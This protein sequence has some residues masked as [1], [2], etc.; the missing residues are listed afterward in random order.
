MGPVALRDHYTLLVLPFQHDVRKADSQRLDS[1]WRPWWW[2]LDPGRLDRTG[3]T[4]LQ[5]AL[6]EPLYFLPHVRHVLYPET[7]RLPGQ[8]AADVARAGLW[9]EAAASDRVA[10][11]ARGSRIEPVVRLTW[12]AWGRSAT[13]QRLTLSEG[14]SGDESRVVGEFWLRWVDAILFPH[15]LG[16]LVL[17]VRCDDADLNHHQL[18]LQ[19]R[20]LRTVHSSYY[21]GEAPRWTIHGE[22]GFSGPAS[23][24]V[25]RLTGALAPETNAKPAKGAFGSHE[26]A[27]A[28]GK[29]FLLMSHAQLVGEEQN[30]GNRTLFEDA[31]EAVLYE[32][33]TLAR[34]DEPGFRPTR[35]QARRLLDGQSWRLWDNW[36]GLA[37][38]DHVVFLARDE[39]CPGL[40]QNVEGPYLMIFAVCLFQRLRLHRLF[41]QMV[42][43][44]ADARRNGRLAHRCWRHFLDFR[45]RFWFPEL[46]LKAQAADIYD[47]IQAG[48]GLPNLFAQVYEEA[49][50]LQ[51]YHQD[52]VERRSNALLNFIAFVAVPIG[53]LAS[54]F[55]GALLKAATWSQFWEWAAVV[56]GGMA[57]LWLAWN[58]R[59]E[60]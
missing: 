37:L 4:L 10:E 8:L 24:L 53:I 13:G 25:A 33:A 17:K 11:L 41:E 9:R 32:L 48:L 40:R 7:A 21:T 34:A 29:N 6:H 43:G 19:L 15:G 23:E 18:A 51:E 57:A 5:T 45:N 36:L 47:R 27:A 31:S 54:F 30:D 14:E 59:G 60:H 26:F 35:E 22:S 42:A 39:Q 2:R 44:E 58:Q 56:G 1:A 55:G 49:Q 16:L 46:S 20:R 28:Y 38:R 50:D 12:S 3:R 52:R